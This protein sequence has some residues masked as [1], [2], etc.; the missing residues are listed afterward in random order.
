MIKGVNQT[1]LKSTWNSSKFSEVPCF[2][3]RWFIHRNLKEPCKLD[4]EMLIPLRFDDTLLQSN[5]CCKKKW[6]CEISLHSSPRTKK[7]CLNFFKTKTKF[8]LFFAGCNFKRAGTL[9]H[10]NYYNYIVHCSVDVKGQIISKANFLVLIWTK[11]WTKL[12][13]DFCPSL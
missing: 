5:Y 7:R 12:F 10:N 11:K 8:I 3:K 2:S 13:V 9:T 6:K 1:C 4:L